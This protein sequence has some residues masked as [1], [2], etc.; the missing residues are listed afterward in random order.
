MN[1]REI[2]SREPS[3]VRR[4]ITQSLTPLSRDL[5]V[6]ETI[7]PAFPVLSGPPHHPKETVNSTSHI[8]G[9]E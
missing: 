6:K 4:T 7:I 2:K 8:N 9:L 1:M 5:M 3:E